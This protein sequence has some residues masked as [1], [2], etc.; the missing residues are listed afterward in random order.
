MPK[1]HVEKSIQHYG[2]RFISLLII[3]LVLLSGTMI[4]QS[5]FGFEDLVLY[6]GYDIAVYWQADGMPRYAIDAGPSRDI[7]ILDED[8]NVISQLDP[9]IDPALAAVSS[10]GPKELA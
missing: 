9:T 10:S 5:E 6:P 8:F 1:Y 7:F 2:L 3:V 4:G